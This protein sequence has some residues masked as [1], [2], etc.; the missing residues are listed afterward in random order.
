[1]QAE[2]L[3]GALAEA[4]Q[5]L[6]DPRQLLAADQHAFARWLVR[7]A[8][9]CRAVGLVPRLIAPHRLAGGAVAVAHQI[10]GGAVEIGERGGDRAGAGRC[11]LEPQLVQQILRLLACATRGEEAQQG[12]AVRQEDRLQAIAHGPVR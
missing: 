12:R 3:A 6:L 7:C 2:D 8:G 4:G 1:M 11:D 9:Q 5:R 10:L